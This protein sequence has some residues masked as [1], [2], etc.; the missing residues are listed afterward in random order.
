M[1]GV[2]R[3]AVR[4]KAEASAALGEQI[5]STYTVA[6]GDK[7]QHPLA[8][9]ISALIWF[10]QLMHFLSSLLTF[11]EKTECPALESRNRK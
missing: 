8:G 7:V 3:W 4:C 11:P 9:C 5:M 2:E 6:L 1:R 10:H